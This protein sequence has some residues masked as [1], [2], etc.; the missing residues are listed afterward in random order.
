MD[1]GTSHLYGIYNFTDEGV[2]S[3]YD[4]AKFIA[5]YAGNK[6]CNI[7]PCLSTEFPSKVKRPA[8]SVLDK[9]KIKEVFGLTIPYWTDSLERCI[10]RIQNK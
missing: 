4:F 5:L 6:G 3:W 7:L 2:C 9:H 1:G 10:R 8:Y